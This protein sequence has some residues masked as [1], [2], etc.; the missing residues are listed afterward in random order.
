MIRVQQRLPLLSKIVSLARL[1]RNGYD[2]FDPPL[3]WCFGV[4]GV[5]SDGDI[6]TAMIVISPLNSFIER[7]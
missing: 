6:R 2:L 5:L 7:A 3:R 1:N 4:T